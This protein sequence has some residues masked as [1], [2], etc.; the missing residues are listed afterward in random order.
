MATSSGAVTEKEKFTRFLLS[1]LL[2]GEPRVLEVRLLKLRAD[3]RRQGRDFQRRF[4][5][6]SSG[7]HHLELKNQSGAC[8]LPLLPKHVSFL[9]LGCNEC[10]ISKC[11]FNSPFIHTRVYRH[12][13]YIH[14]HTYIYIRHPFS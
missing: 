14:T 13:H 12:R 8:K 5:C 2:L 1:T 6:P 7:A 3:T 10:P 9:S 11:I 4:P